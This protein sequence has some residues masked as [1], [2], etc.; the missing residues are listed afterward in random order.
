[1]Q[2]DTCTKRIDG[3]RFW[4][5]TAG[6]IHVTETPDTTEPMKPPFVLQM[7]NPGNAELS[8]DA[9]S[10]YA[11]MLIRTGAMRTLAQEWRTGKAPSQTE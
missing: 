4:T 8:I 7:P 9:V 1:M 3:F 6:R 5:D 2:D 11:E 10:G